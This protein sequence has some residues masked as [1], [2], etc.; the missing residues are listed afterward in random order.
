MATKRNLRFGMVNVGV[1]TEPAIDD[2]ARIK[3]RFGDPDDYGKVK[4]QYVNSSGVVVKPVK[5]Y[6]VGDKAVSLVAHEVAKLDSDQT[7]D[8]VANVET[9]PNEWILSTAIAKPADKTHEDAFALVAH[10]L[11]SNGRVFVG[12]TVANGTTKVLAIRWSEVYGTLVVQ[13]LAYHAQ[14]RWVKADAV[15]AAVAAIPEP[16][17]QMSGMA[18]AIFGAIPDTFDFS[19]VTD[20]YGK[21]L[22]AAVIAKAEGK[23]LSAAVTK[24]T[25]TGATLMETLAA[26]LAA[27]A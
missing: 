10:Y 11:R 5:V 7:I 22:E 25:P 21:A 19:T 20:E 6:E 4:Q 14:V 17:E 24:A 12:R 13:L 2:S 3:G 18:E 27:V 23:S 9:V 1:T 8:L 15:R 16:S 26:S